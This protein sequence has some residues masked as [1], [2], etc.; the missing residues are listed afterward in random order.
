MFLEAVMLARIY[1]LSGSPTQSGS[2]S[3]KWCFY[4]IPED[5]SIDKVMGWVSSSNTMDEV[6]ILFDS[7]E[8]AVQFAQKNHYAFELVRGAKLKCIKKSYAD[9]FI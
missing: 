6:K 8:E 1:Q 9:N 5:K 3:K 7:E 4:F 2:G